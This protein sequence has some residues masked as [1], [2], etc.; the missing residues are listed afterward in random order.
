MN[1][2]KLSIGTDGVVYATMPEGYLWKGR[3][4]EELFGTRTL[5]TPYTREADR[6]VVLQAIQKM[7]PELD[8]AWE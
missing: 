7:N 6:F 8:V 2:I 1:T 4:V 3:S 5:P